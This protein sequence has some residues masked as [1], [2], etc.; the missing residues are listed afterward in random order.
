MKRWLILLA[1]CFTAKD[2]Q[3][4]RCDALCIRDG[5]SSGRSNKAACECVDVKPSLKGYMNR[6]MSLGPSPDIPFKTDPKASGDIKVYFPGAERE[7]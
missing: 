5:Y 4:A 7:W 6:S 2:L 1:V 3:D